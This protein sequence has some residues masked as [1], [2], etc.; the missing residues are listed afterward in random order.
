MGD[1]RAL[2]E[3]AVALIE[4]HWA[5]SAVRRSQYIESEP[6]GYDSPR[7]FLNLGIAIDTTEEVDPYATL[8]DLLTIERKISPAPHRKPDGSYADR[9][10]D[11]DL[12]AIDRLKIVSP[13]LILPHPRAHLRPFVTIP[14]AQLGYTFGDVAGNE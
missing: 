12:I 7:P 6:W 5:S 9:M 8:N 13:R 11:I 1:R 10:I 3:R 4:D 2:I 14:L